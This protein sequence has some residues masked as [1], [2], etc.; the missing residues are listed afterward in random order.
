[1]QIYFCERCGKRISDVDVSKG[2]AVPVEDLV[3]CRGCAEAEGLLE[4]AQPQ[5][6]RAETRAARGTSK[7][8]LPAAQRMPTA[9]P[10]AP[11]VPKWIYGIVVGGV[12]LGLIILLAV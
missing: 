1:M 5:P 6:Q 4:M 3:Y 8:R 7:K 2:A 12:V 10:A 11:G 9:A